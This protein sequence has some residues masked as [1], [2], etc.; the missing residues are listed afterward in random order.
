MCTCGAHALAIMA[1]Q[2]DGRTKFHLQAHL[3]PASGP[4]WLN[5]FDSMK[6]I[7]PW[8]HWNHERSKTFDFGLE[9]TREAPTNAGRVVQWDRGMTWQTVIWLEIMWNVYIK[10]WE[11]VYIP[12]FL[13]CPA[14]S[15]DGSNRVQCLPNMYM[16]SQNGS[17]WTILYSTVV[18]MSKFKFTSL[19]RVRI[20]V[21]HLSMQHSPATSKRLEH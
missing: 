18:Q 4:A 9:N 21:S 16:M 8:R 20:F 17:W 2:C 10:I 13:I 19:T 3:P 1:A 15:V 12:D 14:L 5:I 7:D 11:I 6:F